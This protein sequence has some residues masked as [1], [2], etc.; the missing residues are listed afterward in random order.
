MIEQI[1]KFI[2]CKEYFRENIDKF[3]NAFISH[4]GK[5]AESRIDEVLSKALLIAYRTPQSTENRLRDLEKEKTNELFARVIPKNSS[6]TIEDLTDKSSFEFL[7][8][9]PI[10]H[11]ADFYEVFALSPEERTKKYLEDAFNNLKRTLPELTFEE[12]KEMHD[13]GKILQK[14]SVVSSWIKD[15]LENIIDPATEKKDFEKKFIA[16]KPILEKIDKDINFDNFSY[17]IDNPKIQELNSI[18]AHFPD[19]LKEYH[20]FM[21]Q[22]ADI[23][24]EIEQSKESEKKLS[25]KYYKELIA[26]NMDLVPEMYLEEVKKYLNGENE[27]YFLS[28]KLKS[29]FGYALNLTADIEMF[30]QASEDALAKDKDSWKSSTIKNNRIDFFK[31][32]GI[33]LGDDYEA[34]VNSEQAKSI[35]PSVDRIERF[36]KDKQKLINKY[37]NE[38]YS[39]LKAHKEIR[40]EIEALGLLDKEDSFN[41]SLYTQGGT[42]VNPNVILRNGEYDMF[43]LVVINCENNSGQIDHDIIHELNHLYELY[44]GKTDGKTYSF[45]SG[46]DITEGEMNQESIEEVDTLNSKKDKRDYELFNEIINEMIAQEITEAMHNSG[47]YVFDTPENAK[48]KNVTGYDKT[49]FLA[50]EFFDKY[51]KTIYESRK[52]GNI[53]VLFDEVGK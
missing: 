32:N 5:E 52:N 9:M 10:K 44:L 48:S 30:G 28:S 42:F 8:I 23:K 6:F 40:R 29:F 2:N 50:A 4:Y 38:H 19:I 3:R 17:Y 34:Y 33:D 53:Q 12:L 25:E 43:S 13:T 18:I 27:I 41:A 1:K 14:Y 11:Y 16:A 7:S 37:N 31:A 49:R 22:F 24:E 15:Y 46:W 45:Y 47:V 39:N 35:W 21:S 26:N 36:I 51:R 20:N